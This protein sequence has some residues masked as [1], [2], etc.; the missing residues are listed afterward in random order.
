LPNAA[1]L[2]GDGGIHERV[3]GR[4]QDQVVEDVELGAYAHL[5]GNI[6]GG[7]DAQAHV[8]AAQAVVAGASLGCP[9]SRSVG[10]DLTIG[11]AFGRNGERWH[12]VYWPRRVVALT[13]V[14]LVQVVRAHAEV[15]VEL[16]DL[17]AAPGLFKVAGVAI[18]AGRGFL[19][20]VGGDFGRAFVLF[21][22]RRHAAG[23]AHAGAHAGAHAAHL[24][25]G[26]GRASQGKG[27]RQAN[28]Q[29]RKQ[30]AC[31]WGHSV[32]LDFSWGAQGS[33]L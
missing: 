16:D 5:I 17:G 4:A 29:P 31:L 13:H 14:H 24:R 3:G 23:L 12:G 2:L 27:K 9:G 20:G 18:L 19:L 28:R 21:L 33:T 8:A 22:V 6:D 15:A 1:A 32:D 10:T 11:Q 25:P 30:S 26:R 7:L